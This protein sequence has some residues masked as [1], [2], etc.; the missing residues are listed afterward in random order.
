MN[1]GKCEKETEKESLCSAE[2]G[3][4]DLTQKRGKAAGWGAAEAECG[5]KER[6]GC[7]RKGGPGTHRQRNTYSWRVSTP[8]SLYCSSCFT[9]ASSCFSLESCGHMDE[10]QVTQRRTMASSHRHR[11]SKLLS[12]E[13]LHEGMI[14]RVFTDTYMHMCMRAHP[15]TQRDPLPFPSWGIGLIKNTKNT[16]ILSVTCQNSFKVVTGD[17]HALFVVCKLLL[18]VYILWVY[19][20]F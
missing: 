6:A 16:K 11:R 5:R 9:W 7:G 19:F 13:Y 1:T 2:H 20:I 17:K 4:R 8:I 18:C 15:Q 3:G 10:Q 14:H 12:H